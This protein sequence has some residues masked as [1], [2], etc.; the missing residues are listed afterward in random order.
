[1][2]VFSSSAGVESADR[3]DLD[4]RLPDPSARVQ[5]SNV[6]EVHP[7]G[8]AAGELE[9]VDEQVQQE[10]GRKRDND[11]DDDPDDSVSLHWHSPA[12]FFL[13]FR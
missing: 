9:V 3:A 5:V 12:G 11:D 13:G 7:N 10:R 1:M 8:D 4:P 2:T 6:L